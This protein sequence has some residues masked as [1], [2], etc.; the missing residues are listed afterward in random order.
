M[1]KENRKWPGLVERAVL[2]GTFQP[3]EREDVLL[4]DNNCL[5]GELDDQL[6]NPNDHIAYSPKVMRLC[7]EFA[8]SVF[9]N[10]V[11]KAKELLDRM[12]V[13]EEELLRKKETTN[14]S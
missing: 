14:G 6:V 1:K 10:K 8:L 4:L 13:L 5:C 9:E 7:E 12:N 2:D 11:D 3:E